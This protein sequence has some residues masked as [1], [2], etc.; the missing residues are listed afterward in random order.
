M[1]ESV[2]AYRWR[3]EVFEPAVAGGAA[4]L[5]NSLPAAEVFHEILDHRWYLSERAGHDIGL[6]EAVRAYVDDVLRHARTSGG[7][8]SCC[9]VYTAEE[10]EPC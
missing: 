1:L 2:A 8:A 7:C 3:A 4:E 9:G 10:D 5:W 6:D